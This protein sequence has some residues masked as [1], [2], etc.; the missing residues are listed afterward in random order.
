MR[1]VAE[2]DGADV[3]RLPAPRRDPRLVDCDEPLHPGEEQRGIDSR[4]A[5]TV[6]GYLEPAGV[7]VR[8][9]DPHP[10][11]TASKRLHALEHR[12]PVVQRRIARLELDRAVGDDAGPPPLPV[13]PVHAEHVIAEDIAEPEVVVVDVFTPAPRDGVEF[14]IAEHWYQAMSAVSGP[15]EPD[16]RVRAGRR[17]VE[18]RGIS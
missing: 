18:V 17:K 16:T 14:K 1:F 8:P 7:H 2:D 4:H 5:E 11:V 3:E 6:A 9:E 12:L 13:L 15:S 10:A